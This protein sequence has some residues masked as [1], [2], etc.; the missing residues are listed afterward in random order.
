MTDEGGDRWRRPPYTP[1]IKQR[2]GY[3]F[4]NSSDYVINCWRV[5]AESRARA[6]KA[7][8]RRGKRRAG[9][10]ARAGQG[11]PRRKGEGQSRRRRPHRKVVQQQRHR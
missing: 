9:A 8:R 3:A 4:G 6:A 10:R 5:I 7:R 2:L 1:Q 11:L